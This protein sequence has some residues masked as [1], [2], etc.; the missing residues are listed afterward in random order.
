[1]SDEID[2]DS[3]PVAVKGNRFQDF[4]EGQ[5]LPHHWG[6]TLTDGDVKALLRSNESICALHLNACGLS[7]RSAAAT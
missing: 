3:F 1:M 5:E 7:D 4:S 6:R 2:F